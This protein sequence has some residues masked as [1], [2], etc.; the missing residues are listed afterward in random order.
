MDISNKM[1][2]NQRENFYRSMNLMCIKK[3]YVYTLFRLFKI[4]VEYIR[5]VSIKI[6]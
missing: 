3:I 1:S 6:R 2:I 4:I 5:N